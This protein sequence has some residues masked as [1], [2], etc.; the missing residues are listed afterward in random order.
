MEST[1]V[2]GVGLVSSGVDEVEATVAV[3][4][5]SLSESLAGNVLGGNVG[6]GSENERGHNVDGVVENSPEDGR[7]GGGCQVGNLGKDSSLV[8]LE[9]EV[10]LWWELVN[11][12]VVEG[13][14]EQPEGSHKGNAGLV[15]LLGDKLVRAEGNAEEDYATLVR[16]GSVAVD[17]GRAYLF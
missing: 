13:L 11:A 16:R 7:P 10:V 6:D 2:V 5:R 17:D 8:A 15:K 9:E 12:G 14:E 1:E 3:D 4:G